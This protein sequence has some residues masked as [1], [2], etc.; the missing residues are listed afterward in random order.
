METHGFGNIP[1]NEMLILDRER[2]KR[3]GNGQANAQAVIEAAK[4]LR[5]EIIIIIYVSIPRF[6]VVRLF[7]GFLPALLVHEELRP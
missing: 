2:C 6:M 7:S 3:R 4:D 5:L 1:C